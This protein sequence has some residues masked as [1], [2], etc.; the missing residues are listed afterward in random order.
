V[1][2]GRG[3]L[4]PLGLVAAA[5]LVATFVPRW[6][7]RPLTSG[8]NV[9]FTPGFRDYDRLFPFRESVHG[10]VTTVV[11][12]AGAKTLLSNGKFQG[13]TG[14]ESFFQTNVALVPLTLVGRT[15][16]ALNIGLGTGQTLATLAAV[17]FRRI[18]VAEIAP[19]IVGASRRFFPEL[20]GGAL[21]DPR[22]HVETVDGRNFLLV[23]PE[24]RYDVIAVQVASI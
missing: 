21:D 4:A 8:T 6:D 13:T 1:R 19:D 15:E 23:H 2:P 9:Y 10:G 17:P 14:P 3:S 12:K 11:E 20:H 5:V 24:A 18:D 7:P 16:R 22:V